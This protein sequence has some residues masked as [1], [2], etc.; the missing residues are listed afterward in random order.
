[1]IATID[2]ASLEDHK[3]LPHNYL[4]RSLTAEDDRYIVLGGIVYTV[5]I[6]DKVES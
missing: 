2:P 1:M 3:D 6:T 5:S 4:H